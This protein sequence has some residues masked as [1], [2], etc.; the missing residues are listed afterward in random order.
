MQPSISEA[1]Q[2]SKKVYLSSQKIDQQSQT[3]Y[4]QSSKSSFNSGQ[5]SIIYSDSPP[6]IKAKKTTKEKIS[7]PHNNRAHETIN[8]PQ[9]IDANIESSIRIKTDIEKWSMF[10][11]K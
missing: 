1:V 10:L 3:S 7:E 6:L 4:A 2:T 11:V 8:I 9:E 5:N